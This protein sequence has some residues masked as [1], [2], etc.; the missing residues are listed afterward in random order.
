MLHFQNLLYTIVPPKNQAR[1]PKAD[2]IA[3]NPDASRLLTSLVSSAIVKPGD[4]ARKWHK[5]PAYSTVFAPVLAEKFSK[6][7]VQLVNEKYGD[8][9]KSKLLLIVSLYF[10]NDLFNRSGYSSLSTSI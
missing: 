10:T 1:Y 5:N 9:T 2:S 4:K 6:R 8:Q 3:A 7:L